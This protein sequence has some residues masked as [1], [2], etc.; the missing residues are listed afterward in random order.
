MLATFWLAWL[1]AND[2][3]TVGQ[4]AITAV[5]SSTSTG[6]LALLFLTWQRK[7]LDQERA[8]RVKERDELRSEQAKDKERNLASQERM[9]SLIA[10]CTIGFREST[11]LIERLEARLS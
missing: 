5:A 10:E 1:L 2:T 9:Y 11:K 3:S 8:D 4:S 7:Q 6:G